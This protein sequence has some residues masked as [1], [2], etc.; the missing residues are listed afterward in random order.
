MQTG[1]QIVRLVYCQRPRAWHLL[2]ALLVRFSSSLFH[3]PALRVQTLDNAA[4][5]SEKT[6]S[7]VPELI[8]ELKQ[9]G[10]MGILVSKLNSVVASAAGSDPQSG[11]TVRDSQ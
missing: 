9:A 8:P 6:L 11:H 10:A 5:G 4:H 2:F 1:F 3:F 7:K